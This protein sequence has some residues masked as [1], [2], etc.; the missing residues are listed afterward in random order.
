MLEIKEKCYQEHE[1]KE[2]KTAGDRG[3]LEASTVMRNAVVKRERRTF[4]S[5]STDSGD[6]DASCYM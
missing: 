3:V 4:N 6:R 1:K 2:L 5:Y